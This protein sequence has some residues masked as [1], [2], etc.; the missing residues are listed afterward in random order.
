MTC[1][2]S[3]LTNVKHF[4]FHLIVSEVILRKFW[5]VLFQ[6]GTTEHRSVVVK[7]TSYL[8]YPKFKSRPSYRLF[9]FK[10]FVFS[11]VRHRKCRDCA[12]NL[13]TTT[14]FHKISNLLLTNNPAFDALWSDLLTALLI[15]HN[16]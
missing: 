14:S 7:P 6:N 3:S 13:A 5:E 11:S 8:E 9:R 4:R 15:Y 16:I 2:R 12:S 10:F 1:F